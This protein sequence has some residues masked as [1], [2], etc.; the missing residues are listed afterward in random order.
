ML[1]L[2]AAV[3]SAAGCA[4]SSAGP[5]P[6][7]AKIAGGDGDDAPASPKK[8]AARASVTFDG[9]IVPTNA[10]MLRAPQNTFRVAGW[11][12][13]SSWI[14]LQDLVEDGTRVAKGD[15]VA[16]FEFN[17]RRALPR[18]QRN[19]QSAEAERDKATLDVGRQ[20]DQM[21]TDVD[22]RGL[23]A[24]RAALDTRKEGLVSERDLRRLEIAHEQATFE[25]RAQSQQ[26]TAYQRT[27]RAESAFYDQK[28]TRAEQ[29]MQ[30]YKTY[31]ERFV[32]SA[33]HDGVVRHAFLKWKRRKVQIGD[34]MPGGRHFLSVAKDRELSVE[35]FIPEHRFALT[36]AQK[37]FVV[38]SPS[39]AKTYPAR[40]ERVEPFPQELG[41]LK[42]DESLPNAREK[43]YVVHAVFDDEVP[44]ELSAGSEVEVG[45]P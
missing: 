29:D 40:V 20:I 14:K 13:N 38:H 26:L 37:E 12:S 1:C 44:A 27:L 18:V 32:V 25:E 22:K 2:L 39:S 15:V 28:V 45:L 43:M 30:R 17:G 8:E 31:E 33:P 7:S 36:T 21:R 9:Y 24:A 16:R 10:T 35:F 19:I 5:E 42:E 41:F 11:N 4:E 6:A 23:D 34:G 3:A